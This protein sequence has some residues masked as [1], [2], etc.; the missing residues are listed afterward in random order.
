VAIALEALRE[1]NPYAHPHPRPHPH[2]HP[3]PNARSPIALTLTL[4]LTPTPSAGGG[5]RSVV[6]E[7]AARHAAAAFEERLYT[8]GHGAVRT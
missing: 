2:R 7:A 4:T 5:A 6:R 3:H 8:T 1:A